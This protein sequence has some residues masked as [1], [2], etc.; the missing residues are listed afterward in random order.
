VTGVD[1][2][3]ALDIGVGLG[4][5]LVGI[6]V[7]W[8][9]IALA[10]TLGRVNNTLDGIDQQIAGLGQPVGKTLKHLGGIADSADQAVARLGAVVGSLE[11]VAGTVSQTATLAKDALSPAIVNIGAT[12]AGVSAGLRRLVKGRRSQ[13]GETGIDE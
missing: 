13:N 2:S 8:A 11:D 7:L 6:G 12:I 9:C 1:W 10:K 3:M 4:V 5:L